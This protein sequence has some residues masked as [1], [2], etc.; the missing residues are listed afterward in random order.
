MRFQIE[1]A[2]FSYKIE[3]FQ[4]DNMSHKNLLQNGYMSVQTQYL[5]SLAS[6]VLLFNLLSCFLA[7]FYHENW[8]H[9]HID[10]VCGTYR[11]CLFQKHWPAWRTTGDWGKKASWRAPTAYKRTRLRF[12]LASRRRSN[13]GK[14][15]HSMDSTWKWE[16]LVWEYPVDP[17]LI[18][19]HENQLEPRSHT[20]PRWR[21]STGLLY[22]HPVLPKT[23]D[24]VS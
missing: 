4:W 11:R 17:A 2:V 13:L 23:S 24:L 6:T 18:N 16:N 9:I 8:I 10:L 19:M 3:S 14:A 20:W 5:S 12:S 7:H 21:S 1:A 22:S 15:R